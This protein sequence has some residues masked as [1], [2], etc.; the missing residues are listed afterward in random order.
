MAR[1]PGGTF[2]VVIHDRPEPGDENL[3]NLAVAHALSHRATV[4]V[5]EPEKVSG[6]A[7]AVAI[8]W[9]ESG[10]RSSKTI[11]PVIP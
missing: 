2:R 6:N 9:F 8:H 4:R 10:R 11:I 3:P 1:R 7:T 5:V